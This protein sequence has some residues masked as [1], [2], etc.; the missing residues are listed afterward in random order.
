MGSG[1]WNVLP[2]STA[3]RFHHRRGKHR[4]TRNGGF[5]PRRK[6][7]VCLVPSAQGGKGHPHF[8]LSGSHSVTE[9]PA[10]KAHPSPAGQDTH[11][12]VGVGNG[13]PLG[14]FPRS[15]RDLGL[16]GNRL[17]H[18]TGA[19]GLLDHPFVHRPFKCAQKAAARSLPGAPQQEQA[20]AA[21][22]MQYLIRGLSR[23]EFC[24]ILH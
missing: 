24:L 1:V 22:E 10:S 14:N 16:F 7:L 8:V 15:S 5:R 20:L 21:Q 18:G 11:P 2:A 23:E 9:L 4:K 13:K 17:L 6:G 12:T 3:H 19:N